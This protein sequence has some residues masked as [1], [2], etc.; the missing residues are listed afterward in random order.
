MNKFFLIL[1]CV[2][3]T[4]GCKKPGTD[5]DDAQPPIPVK[6]IPTVVT[7]DPSIVTRYYAEFSGLITDTGKATINDLG[8]VID[9]LPMPTLTQNEYKISISLDSIKTFSVRAGGLPVNK[10]YFVPAYAQNPFGVAYGEAVKFASFQEKIFNDN[11]YLKT[12]QQVEEFGAN[13]YSRIEGELHIEGPVTDLTPLKSLVVI[14]SGV[15]IRN[16]LLVNFKGLENLEFT[17]YVFPNNFR[18]ESNRYLRDFTGLSG[19]QNTRGYFYILNNPS[20]TSVDGLDSFRSV[21]MGEFRIQDCNQLENIDGL[22]HMIFVGSDIYLV[23]NARLANIEGL[24]NLSTI[25]FGLHIIN[26]ASLQSL[27]GLEK[28]EELPFGFELI[29]DTSL[30]DIKGI[31]NLSS[32]GEID[33]PGSGVI[34]IDGNTSLKDLSAFSKITIADYLTISNNTLLPNL[35]GFDNLQVLKNILQIDNNPALLNLAGL[36]KLNSIACLKLS[37]NNA[38]V[39]LKS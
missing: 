19:L 5:A 38:L 22:K 8:F 39:D 26:N 10:Y 7:N 15:I 33:Y 32:V 6:K 4:N 37:N 30:S 29:N 23:N 27:D 25:K 14:N 9:T 28:I 11:V 36:E 18:I 21:G 24:R 2:F 13:N 3:L 34:I 35:K 12:Q 20:L 17:G 16:T 31:R 1:L